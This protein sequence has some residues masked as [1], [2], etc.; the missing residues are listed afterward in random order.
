[1]CAFESSCDVQ[2]FDVVSY[3]HRKII[4]NSLEVIF[5]LGGGDHWFIQTASMFNYYDIQLMYIQ[6]SC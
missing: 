6:I 4:L 1:M 5:V 2:L 3:G